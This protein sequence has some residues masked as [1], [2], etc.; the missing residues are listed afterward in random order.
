MNKIL[1]IDQMRG[2]SIDD[3]ARLYR[4]GYRIEENLA[5][6]GVYQDE[7][8][9]IPYSPRGKFGF[10]VPSE[11]MSNKKIL[12]AQNGVTIGTGALLLIGLGAFLYLIL[13]K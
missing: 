10:M 11:T 8:E 4:D 13:K 6:P 9:I 12:T 5:Y 3:I 7:N 2:M 1:T